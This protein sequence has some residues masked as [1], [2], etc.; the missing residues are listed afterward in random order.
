MLDKTTLPDRIFPKPRLITEDTELNEPTLGLQAQEFASFQSDTDQASQLEDAV[1]D[2]PEV[3]AV[4]LASFR[5]SNGNTVE[6][7]GLPEIG[8]IGY[9]EIGKSGESTPTFSLHHNFTTLEKF[10]ILSREFTSIP[11]MLLEFDNHDNKGMLIAARTGDVVD[12]I[13]E[14]LEVNVDKLVLPPL[15]AFGDKAKTWDCS[16]GAEE[17]DQ[18]F[19]Q[20]SGAVVSYCDPG[21]WKTLIRSSWDDKKKKWHKCKNS[22]AITAVC[23][24]FADVTHYWWNATS[25]RVR[26][27]KPNLVGGHWMCSQYNGYG[28]YRRRVKHDTVWKTGY[29]RGYTAF[30][31]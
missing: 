27:T 5:L 18:S 1:D 25:W 7:V 8:E 15:P 30:H 10:L 21:Q 20:G 19:C 28:K 24:D 17:F 3:R 12:T 16:K 11:R 9:T 29:L 13:P 14:P 4:S 23:Q 31:N 22:F 2:V 6:F 26:L